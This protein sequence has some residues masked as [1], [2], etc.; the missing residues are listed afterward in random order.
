MLIDITDSYGENI[1]TQEWLDTN[2]IYFDGTAN[3][4]T[5]E[6][7]ENEVKFKVTNGTGSIRCNNGGEGS[8][9]SDGTVTITGKS[10]NTTC[11]IE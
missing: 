9:N 5:I 8:I 4:K 10:V 1:L 7:G 2:L 3:M 6:T 11:V